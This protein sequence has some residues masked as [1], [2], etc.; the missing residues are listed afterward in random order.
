MAACRTESQVGSESQEVQWVRLG[1]ENR[2]CWGGHIQVGVA[3]V[4][5]RTLST[6]FPGISSHDSYPKCLAGLGTPCLVLVT[7]PW[8]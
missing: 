8:F 3:L 5:L 1:G 6:F 4:R 2:V 7:K